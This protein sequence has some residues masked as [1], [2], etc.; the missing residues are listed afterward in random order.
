MKKQIDSS[1]RHLVVLWV[2]I[3]ALILGLE[4]CEGRDSGG[5]RIWPSLRKQEGYSFRAQVTGGKV[6][7]K[8]CM[9]PATLTCTSQVGRTKIVPGD[10]VDPQN[11]AVMMAVSPSRLS[12]WI[13][14]DNNN[15][16]L[17]L[18]CFP[19]RP[20][21]H[22]ANFYGNS[23]CKKYAKQFALQMSNYQD[24][25]SGLS[26]GD[27]R[28]LKNCRSE[29][30]SSW[31]RPAECEP[32]GITDPES[33]GVGGAGGN[34]GGGHGGGG[35]GPGAGGGG[36]PGAGGG[37]GGVKTPWWLQ[38]PQVSFSSSYFIVGNN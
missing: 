5:T 27:G 9:R 7:Q 36:G 22:H 38:G 31:V 12:I 14:A 4:V 8:K 15:P 35:G 30:D 34:D 6:V 2:V 16:K 13:V 17:Q 18:N 28:Y 3:L 1:F 32:I 23:L 33:S 29:E 20:G 19:H 26:P 24:N 25:P 10:V 37:G 11:P 21:N